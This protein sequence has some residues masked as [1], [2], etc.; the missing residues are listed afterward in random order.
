MV[1]IARRIFGTGM[2]AAGPFRGQALDASTVKQ[3]YGRSSCHPGEETITGSALV[4]VAAKCC[5]EP[6]AAMLPEVREK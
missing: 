5:G 4:E 3:K 2:L 1:K 6:E